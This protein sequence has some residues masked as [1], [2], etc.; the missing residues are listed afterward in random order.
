MLEQKSKILTALKLITLALILNACA[1]K[2]MLTH[3]GENSRVVA[4]RESMT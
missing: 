1:S 2:K 4:L 3:R